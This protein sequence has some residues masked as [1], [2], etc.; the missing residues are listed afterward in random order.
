MKLE[1][2]NRYTKYLEQPKD[3]AMIGKKKQMKYIMI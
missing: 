2:R 3:I 1:F